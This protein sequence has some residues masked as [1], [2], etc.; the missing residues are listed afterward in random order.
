MFLFGIRCRCW[1]TADF[2]SSIDDFSLRA[3]ARVDSFQPFIAYNVFFCVNYLQL[4]SQEI[5]LGHIR[6]STSIH[7]TDR[8][9][10]RARGRGG[11][12]GK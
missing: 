12:R 3:L 9:G 8:P 1:I 6:I 7:A 4:N 11:G 2:F 5:S 10:D